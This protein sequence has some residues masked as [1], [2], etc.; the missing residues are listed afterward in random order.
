MVDASDHQQYSW[1]RY[2]DQVWMTQNLNKLHGASVCYDDLPENCN[3]YGRLY[4]QG[5]AIN[6]CPVG[7][8]IPTDDEWQ[9]FEKHM[10]VPDSLLTRRGYTTEGDLQ[11]NLTV[12]YDWV[13][14]KGNNSSGFNLLPA[15]ELVISTLRNFNS[16]HMSTCL[17]TSTASSSQDAFVRISNNYNYGFFR[18][19]WDKT[20]GCSARC[21][22]D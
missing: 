8:H 21:V 18:D 6:S 17:W 22:Q 13:I 10:G 7:W 15:G 5:A 3:T 4:S 12:D 9:V 2:G 16:L 1:K 11:T 14:L 20:D 19:A